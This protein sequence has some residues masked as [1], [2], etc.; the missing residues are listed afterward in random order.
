MTGRLAQHVVGV[1]F[2]T[3]GKVYHFDAAKFQEIVQGDLVVVETSR[4][5]Q[6]GEVTQ[7]IQD[8]KTIKK[9]RLRPIM[10]LA[11]PVD[12]LTRQT[13][14]CQEKA[15]VEQCQT[16]LRESGMHTAKVVTTEFSYDGERVTVLV[17]SEGEQKLDLKAIRQ[18]ISGVL[19]DKTIDVRQI[20]PRDVAKVIGGMGACGIENRC[21]SRFLTDFCSISIRMAKE[22]GISLTPTEITGICGRLRCCLNYEYEHYAAM[23]KGLPKKNKKVNTPMGIGKVVEVLTLKEAVLVDLPEAGVKEFSKEEISPVDPSQVPQE[24]KD[25]PRPAGKRSRSK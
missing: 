2:T 12:L 24:K 4:G 25:R 14:K 7:L 13:R 23:R 6:L 9:G 16:R 15:A 3:G 22:Q 10:R 21:C 11:T 5:I 8:E 1:R 20:G 18:K 17:S 19:R